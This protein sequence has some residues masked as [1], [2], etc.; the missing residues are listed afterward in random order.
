MPKVEEEQR[1]LSSASRVA[2]E[3]HRIKSTAI[4]FI[5][6]GRG[7]SR[8]SDERVSA[9]LWK[10]AFAMGRLASLLTKSKLL[11]IS[12]HPP[13]PVTATYPLVS[14]PGGAIPPVF[15]R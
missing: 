3:F 5:I 15:C 9:Q 2:E 11:K 1:T 8:Y 10:M 12:M 7:D 4:A 6:A 13:Y 14:V